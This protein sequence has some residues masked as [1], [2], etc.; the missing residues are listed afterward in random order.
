[1]YMPLILW[2]PYRIGKAFLSTF[3]LLFNFRVMRAMPWRYIVRLPFRDAWIAVVSVGFVGGVVGIL[4]RAVLGGD[5]G[6]LFFGLGLLLVWVA[7]VSSWVR[8]LTQW[9]RLR[10]GGR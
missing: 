5:P 2:I 4:G 9:W 1:M 10:H 7:L 3:R 8:A 6:E